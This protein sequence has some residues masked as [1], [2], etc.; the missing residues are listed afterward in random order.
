VSKSKS[1]FNALTAVAGIIFAVQGIFSHNIYLKIFNC[2]GL[3]F[4]LFALHSELKIIYGNKLRF[5]SAIITCLIIALFVLDPLSKLEE[6]E[7]QKQIVALKDSLNVLRDSII[8]SKT[9]VVLASNSK[10]EAKEKLEFAKKYIKVANKPIISVS[11]FGVDSLSPEKHP[12]FHFGIE[13]VGHGLAIQMSYFAGVMES[14]KPSCDTGLYHYDKLISIP[15]MQPQ[16]TVAA[17]F[18]CADPL[19][20][21]KFQKIKNKSVFL[22]YYGVVY[23]S[24]EFSKKDSIG[25]CVVYDNDSPSKFRF[26]PSHNY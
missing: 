10:E 12:V 4:L 1:L 23:Y 3:I 6:S 21:E 24:D 11:D 14:S 15:A 25:F 13:N 2:I 5:V 19:S 17:Y 16:K 9:L 8:N 26:N 22:Y 18:P 7:S 20:Q